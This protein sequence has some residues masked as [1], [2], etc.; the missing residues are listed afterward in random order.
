MPS[1]VSPWT[2]L[3]PALGAFLGVVLAQLWTSRREKWQWE[4]Q[5][6]MYATQWADQR[7][8]DAEQ[9][10]DQRRRD[11]EQWE[12]EDRHRFTAEKRDLYANF[13]EA[14]SDYVNLLLQ[15]SGAFESELERRKH[16]GEGRLPDAQQWINQQTF[17]ASLNEATDAFF[18]AYNTVRLVASPPIDE[19]T[20][21]FHFRLSDFK[22]VLI[23][24]QNV[25]RAYEHLEYVLN[26]NMA[27]IAAMRLDLG[28]PDEG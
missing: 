15:L 19:T 3:V 2:F 4:N 24:T 8:R 22:L 26:H 18:K 5:M 6:Q 14:L 27:M 21:S 12:R 20:R 23:N 28:V 17:S 9:R 10:E 7:E 1:T 13:T 25:S 16:N 11:R